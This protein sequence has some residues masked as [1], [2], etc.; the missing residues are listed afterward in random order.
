MALVLGR[1][2][3]TSGIGGG[4]WTR[5]SWSLEQEEIMK[6]DSDNDG[7]NKL[8]KEGKTRNKWTRCAP[9]TTTYLEAS[10]ATCG[11]V[12][13][14]NVSPY[15][16]AK[17]RRKLSLKPLRP[18]IAWRY[19]CAPAMIVVLQPQQ[20]DDAETEKEICDWFVEEEKAV[21]LGSMSM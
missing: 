7:N 18:S 17:G 12:R 13:I 15:S 6:N 20:E 8:T 10:N 4:S 5:N 21:S 2:V 14:C 11:V 1:F 19:G 16:K 3:R 9:S